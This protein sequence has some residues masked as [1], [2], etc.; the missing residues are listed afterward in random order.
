MRTINRTRNILIARGA[1]VLALL[2]LAAAPADAARRAPL[3]TYDA[4]WGVKAVILTDGSLEIVQ[5][6]PNGSPLLAAQ[7]VVPE[8]SE[9]GR[10]F[11]GGDAYNLG[12]AAEGAPGGLRGFSADADDDHDG[13]VDEDRLDGVDNDGDGRIDEDYAAVSDAMIAVTRGRAGALAHVEHYRWNQSRLQGAMFASAAAPAGSRWEMTST[14][15]PWQDITA[16]V[17]LHTMT[18]RTVQRTVSAFVS[19]GWPDADCG[20]KMNHWVGVAV[21][22]E[23]RPDRSGRARVDGRTLAVSLGAEPLA[24]VVCVADSWQQLLRL[25]AE[26]GR[27]RNGVSDPV[28]GVRAPWIATP[29]CHACRQAA[30][31]AFRWRLDRQGDLVLAA[32]LDAGCAA[33]PDPDLLTVGEARLGSPA[34]LLWTP[35]EGE[36]RGAAWNCVGAATLARSAGARGP[37]T[38]AGLRRGD[39]AGTLELRFVDPSPE[40]RDMLAG[41]LRASDLSLDMVT[42]DG[43]KAT[44]RLSR[45]VGGT[46]PVRS[47]VALLQADESALDAPARQSQLLRSGHSRV[48]LAPDLLQGWPNPFRDQI[49]VRFRVPVTIEEAFTWDEDEDRPA[50]LDPAAPVPWQAGSPTATVKIY[51]M[52]GQEVASLYSAPSTAGEVAVTWNG[53][54]AFGRKVASGTYFCKLQLDEWSVTRRIVYLR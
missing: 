53:A 49:T 20:L 26:A 28:T 23:P 52:S 17:D 5:P 15:S 4:A 1:A 45:D 43:R 32:D 38:L 29:G 39:E 50:G 8:T 22:D 54:D 46:D 35:R 24:V 34:G 3:R 21:L 6:S 2:L 16:T 44:A 36:A 19:Q 25:L 41:V 40:L 47:A 27:V 13:L 33:L 31:P 42:L 12:R 30:A 18:G 7:V 37:A 9:R 11:G 14:G 51:T 48:Q 10:A